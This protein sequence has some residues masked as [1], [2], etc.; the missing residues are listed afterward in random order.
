ME[1]DN[2]IRYDLIAEA[3]DYY[4]SKG[5]VE[6]NVPWHVRPEIS[7]LTCPSPDRAYP[8][9]DGVFVGSAE[10]SMIQMAVDGELVE[11][12]YY[13]S[14]SPCFRNEPVLDQLHQKY[15]MKVELFHFGTDQDPY[16]KIRR[17][18]YNFFRTLTNK[19]IYW[20]F[21]NESETDTDFEIDG[22][23]IGSYNYR[24]GL[25]ITWTCGTGLALPRF[26]KVM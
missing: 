3:L 4:K 1:D 5:Y 19:T 21:E 11:G 25:G 20:T 8:F 10:Q 23:E 26:T 9:E 7:A 14:C 24:T 17:D 6:I 16:N 22:V 15:F 18:A 12:G 13:V 2:L